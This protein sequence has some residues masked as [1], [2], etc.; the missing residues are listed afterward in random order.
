MSTFNIAIAGL[1]TVGT[2][3]I[4][5]LQSNAD[6]IIA[7]TGRRI[8]VKAVSARDKKKKRD[9]DMTG[10]D[11]F[12]DP[13][14]LAQLPGVDAVVELIGGAEGIAR[15]VALSA[16]KSGKNFVTANKALLAAHG[17][18]LARLAESTKIQLSFEASVAGGIPI[19]KGIREAMAANRINSVRGILNGTCNYILTRMQAGK[20]SFNDALQEA[21]RHGYAEA[22]PA[23]D[24]DGHDTARKVAILAA[25]AFGAEPDF[26][27]VEVEGIRNIAPLDL[28]FA[29]ELQ[30]RIK[31]LGVARLT[32]AGLEQYVGPCLVPQTSPLAGVDGALNAVQVK[33]DFSGDLFFEGQGAGAEPTASAVVADLIDLARGHFSP[34]FGIPAAQLKKLKAVKAGS[35]QM[36]CWYMRLQ[37][38]DKPGVVADISAILRDEAISIESL[39]QH[40]RS[41]T[42]SVPVVI[43]THAASAE[44][45][46]RAIGKMARLPTIIGQPCLLQIE[47]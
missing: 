11:W 7:R 28:H 26:A 24:I 25:L 3:V 40:G 36:A 17:A 33:G 23:A 18:E 35:G 4:R 30:H 34:A 39:L 22:D 37:V 8:I 12:D 10:C 31:L 1:G 15:E 43:T 5:L 9:C 46:R 32:E 47:N 29:D 44:V 6:F 21:Q 14:Q 45:M 19:I 13:R 2:G 42:E 27:S 38:V 16:L 41:Q 20:L